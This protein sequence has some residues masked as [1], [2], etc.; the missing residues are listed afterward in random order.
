MDKSLVV[1]EATGEGVLRYRMLEPVRQYAREK[2]EESGEAESLRSRHARF[3]LALAEEAAP[4]LQERDQAAWVKRL[5]TEHPDLRAALEWLLDA[6]PETALRLAATVGLFWY[7]Y[8]HISE[9]RRWLEASLERTE[10]LETATRA[11]ALRLA[12]ILLDESGLYERAEKLYEEGLSIYRRLGDKKGVAASLNS[13]GALKYAVGEM[14]QAIALTKESLLL[15]RELGDRKS[16]A[17]SLNNLGEMTHTAGDLSGAQALFEEC[18]EL[19]EEL[20][21][22]W[23]IT[24]VLLN[25]GTLAVEQGNPDR[26]DAL[27]FDALRTFRRLGD[28]DAVTDCLGSLAE[29]AGMRGERNRTATLLG[30]AEAARESLGTAIR[31]VE[32][33]RHE[34]FVAGVRSALGEE[35]FA[36]L[37]SRGRAM[38]LEEAIEYALAAG[39]E[40]VPEAS[41]E[42]PRPSALT[43]REQEIADLIARGFTNRRIAEE[44]FISER[45]VATHVSRILKKLGLRSREQVAARTERH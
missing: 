24:I 9:G 13:L 40:P 4:M 29:A 30:A 41:P 14:D 32:R 19:D 8:G 21:D 33:D 42:E 2:L 22:S 26:A 7:R 10:G 31:P 20:E 43:R 23:G 37:W 15:K 44:L 12:G 1:A 3:F 36:G 6:E 25:L 39:E 18:L 17:S 27:L 38:P 45:T 5:E 28:M 11:R 16:I 34:R 35:A